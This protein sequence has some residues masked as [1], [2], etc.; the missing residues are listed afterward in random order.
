MPLNIKNIIDVQTIISP[1]PQERRD[2]RN[3]LFT[4]DGVEVG[5]Q[6]INLY[7]TYGD[8]V[9]AYG[10]T[11]EPAKAANTFFSG[12]FLGLKPT[13]FY[14]ANFESGTETLADVINDLLGDPRYYML[15]IEQGFSE[16][17][18]IEWIDAVEAS[19]KISYL[20]SIQSDDTEI[21]DTDIVADT[22]SIAKYLYDNDITKTFITYAP[23]MGE[24][25]ALSPLSYF[26]TV[27][28]TSARPLG[29]LAY[30]QFSG[31]T[32]TALTDGESANLLSK[33]ANFYAAFG[34]V[35]RNIYYKG[36]NGKGD[37]VDSWVGVD[38][39]NYNITYN[40]FDLMI[41][42]PRLAFT[43]EDFTKLEQ[44][45]SEV[46]V[47]V[48]EAGLIAGGTDPDTD[49]D[50]PYGYKVTIPS[51][52]DVSSADKAAGILKN[53]TCV[54]LLAGSAIKFTI[55]NVLKY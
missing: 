5:G 34:E 3:V 44:A 2:F 42:L 18:N 8:V 37:F 1:V 9:D 48:N 46:F 33:N 53:I 6:R 39:I 29:V 47:N 52:N 38:Y 35:G 13:N 32:A 19:T 22:G 30:K 41:T 55:T 10:S 16:A 49:E 50:L 4:F 40:I 7:T 45:I 20:L 36:V 31:I 14:V 11:S 27:D 25:Q 24:Y 12:G 51:P 54:G 28:F 21:K 23:D 26:A 43:T 15:A 17:Q